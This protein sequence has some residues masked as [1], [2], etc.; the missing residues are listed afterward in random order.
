MGKN[1]VSLVVERP[2]EILTQ[3]PL[4]HQIAAVYD[5]YVEQ[6]RGTGHRHVSTPVGA[7]PQKQI[8]TRTGSLDYPGHR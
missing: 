1:R 7:G 6:Q 5:R 2:A 3:I 8:L 4:I